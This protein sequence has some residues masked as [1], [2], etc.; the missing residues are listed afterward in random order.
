MLGNGLMTELPVV[1]AVT[2]NAGDAFFSADLVKQARQHRGVSG[3][4]VSHFDSSNLQRSC[5]NAQV[6]LAPLATI[7]GAML[8]GFSLAFA[9]HL[10]AG[11]VD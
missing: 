7:V 8:F 1:G 5:V 10:D 6:N 3:R 11:A 9:E 4:I 2:T